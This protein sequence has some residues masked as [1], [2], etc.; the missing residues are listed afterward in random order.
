MSQPPVSES[1]KD[2]IEGF[3]LSVDSLREVYHIPV[4]LALM[5]FM[6]WVRV[7]NWENFVVDGRVLFSGNDAWYHFR[8][9]QYTVANFPGTMP[10]DPWTGFPEGTAVGQFGT[11]FD[12]LI[13]LGALV[14]GLGSP[15]DHQIAMVH[16]FAP[17]IFG[18]A[19]VIPVYFIG[20]R[21]GGRAGGLVAALLLA[22]TPGQFLTR[23]LAGFADH[24]V[25]EALFMAM[26]VAA[27]L[28]AIDTAVREKPVFELLAANEY[29]ALYPSVGPAA[30][31]G[32]LLG[33]YMWVWPP[34]VFLVGIVG[35]YFGVTLPLQ[36]VRG[37]SPDHLAVAG[38][39]LGLVTAAVTLVQ[40]NTVE[41]TATDVSLVQPTL[42]LL[43]AVECAVLAGGARLWDRRDLE[44]R[45]FPFAVGTLV[46]AGALVLAVG[47]PDLFG[48]FQEQ[49][50][51]VFGLGATATALTVGEAQPPA[52][53]TTFLYNSYGLALFTGGLGVAY[54]LYR[55][56]GSRDLKPVYL[57]VSLWFVFLVLATLTQQRFD[58][59][60]ALAV[61]ATNAALIPVLVSWLDL[62]EVVTSVREVKAYQVLSVLAILLVLTAPLAYRTG[63]GYANAVQIS[64]Q[65]SQP[66]EVANWDTTL[67]WTA[68]NTPVE[69]TYGSGGEGTLEYYGTYDR[70]DD[71][72]YEEGEYGV[73]AWWDYGH[74]ITVLG[75]RV[76]VANPF[77][78][79][80]R[81]A[82]NYLLGDN[83]TEANE[84]LV[85]ESG[86]E[87]RY[88]MID[89]Q[90]GLAG[91]QKFSA[92]AAWERDHD[93]S[94][95]D[96]RTPVYAINRQTGGVQL[97]Y[98][99]KSQR[100]M[101]SMRSRLYEFHGSAVGPETRN[102]AL[103]RQVVVADWDVTRFQSGQSVPTVPTDTQ[104]IKVRRNLTAA[105][106]YVR[107]NGSAQVGGVLGEPQEKIP[108][109]KHYRLVYASP[110]RAETPASRGYRF[111]LA[112]QGQQATPIEVQQWVKVFE[113]VPGATVDGQGPPNA[114]VQAAVRMRIPTTNSS[115]LYIQEAETDAGGNFEMTLPY[116]STGYEEYG[117][118]AGYTN[119]SVRA[120]TAYR[121]TVGP[122]TNE[123]LVTSVW[124]ADANVTEG[125]VLGEVDEP[126]EVTLEERVISRPEGANETTSN[127]TDANAIDVNGTAGNA[128]S[129]LTV[130]STGTDAAG[131]L[132]GP[133][134]P[135]S[136]LAVPS[137]RTTAV[138]PGVGG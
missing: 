136:T 104:P 99:V 11:L 15:T 123:T 86:E 28:V 58:Y 35:I 19:T 78:Q 75:E 110:E 47:L 82:A 72:Q 83:E 107:Q 66:G 138:A 46:F 18:V 34:G 2:A 120:E 29:R 133:V 50:F 14:V 84:L 4:L 27:L 10:F 130:P 80:A 43:L 115:F 134:A 41:L 88:V 42:A 54:M 36:H 114:T 98:A 1:L 32:L 108:A 105:Q 65:Q 89:Y 30:L 22:L 103:G 61:S 93:V 113:R 85:S 45:A 62:D 40:L 33:L 135:R 3:D 5:A 63:G 73:M 101:E 26:A 55:V 81:V 44:P 118:E 7:R 122:V 37:E 119:V 111:A 92:P 70:T 56:I 94:A 9:V 69:G 49:F 79:N 117:T 87:T 25:G 20:K 67:D 77:Q 8:M 90:L 12:Q 57:F 129:S 116:S 68:A 128:S 131:D 23:S 52:D 112:Q 91:T 13:A 137:V 24:Q 124:T 95:A 126:V 53:P 96:L 121:F 100:S 59:Y 74:W 17:A 31:A 38:I 51:R 21:L 76:P 102:S 39:V 48:Y 6:L 127:T 71:F 109:L 97:A 64:D 60:L 16:L 125:Q 106:Q 132:E